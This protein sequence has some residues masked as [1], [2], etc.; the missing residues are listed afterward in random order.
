MIEGRITVNPTVSPIVVL[1]E[2]IKLGYLYAV[3]TLII[4]E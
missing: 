1:A 3:L 2:Y 4:K